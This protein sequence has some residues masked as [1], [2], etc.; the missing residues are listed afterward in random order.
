MENAPINDTQY[1]LVVF[2]S[3]RGGITT[4]TFSVYGRY[5]ASI[6]AIR[7]QTRRGVVDPAKC[8]FITSVFLKASIKIVKVNYYE[9]YPNLS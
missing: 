8:I 6:W 5:L 4:A 3:R 9:M 7:H 2:K 1:L